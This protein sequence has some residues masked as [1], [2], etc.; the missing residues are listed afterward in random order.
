M[1]LFGKTLVLIFWLF[2]Q[3]LGFAYSDFQ[4]ATGKGWALTL[5]PHQ[6]ANYAY[7]AEATPGMLCNFA[8]ASPTTDGNQ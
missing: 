7:D 1:N 8:L 4:S 6:T 2:S 5:G 3:W